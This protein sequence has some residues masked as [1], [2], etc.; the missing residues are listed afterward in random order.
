MVRVTWS[1]LRVASSIE[2]LGKCAKSG[3]NPGVHDRSG[4]SFQSEVVPDWCSGTEVRSR[5]GQ[6]AQFEVRTPYRTGGEGIIPRH[7]CVEVSNV[8]VTGPLRVANPVCVLP[9]RSSNLWRVKDGG[10]RRLPG[11][12]HNRPVWFLLRER[13][14]PS[15]FSSAK[16]QADTPLYEPTPSPFG[17]YGQ[18]GSLF[19]GR[20][21]PSRS[22]ALDPARAG[23]SRC[24]G[25]RV[26][27]RPAL[28]PSCGAG[29]GR[30]GRA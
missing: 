18:N 11:T 3:G 5:S 6:P 8:R 30:E 12:G 7:V 9:R 4:C 17:D 22:P 20:A 16:Y 13:R 10:A 25:L 24:R 26:K 27:R 19:S 2:P 15:P 23:L 21:Y 14:Q 28:G 1:S 29:P